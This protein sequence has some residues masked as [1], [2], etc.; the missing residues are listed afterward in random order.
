MHDL[1]TTRLNI[2]HTLSAPRILLVKT[3]SLGDVIHNLPVVSDIAHHYP[4]AR[5]DWLV[6]E[7]FAALPA[8]HPRVRKVIP[9]AIRRWRR[10]LFASSTWRE[11][12]A[13]R[14]NL[15]DEQY[16]F[17][18]DTQGLFKSALL[19]SYARGLRCGYDRNSAREPLA[20]IFY[21]K[22]FAVARARHAVERN[23]QLVASALDYALSDTADFGIVPPPLPRPAW[24][25]EGRYAVLLHATSRDDKLWE[26]AKWVELG[27]HFQLKGIAGILPWGN[28]NE[29]A[30]AARLA[31]QIPN[32]ICTPKMNLN[33][34]AALLGAAYAVIGVDT[35]IA[36]LAAALNKPTIGIYTA[37]DPALTG[38]YAGK[39]TMNLG[40]IANSPDV[41]DVVNA[42]AK[43][44]D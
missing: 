10:N 42:L 20:T 25:A 12:H 3:S 40:G 44:S 37:T 43:L 16:D 18:I 13:L 19:M 22:T 21:Q 29:Q 15:A 35:G 28:A 8:L 24:L 7:G 39:L 31:A 27:K 4:N 9:V 32:A 34:V 17:V 2:L 26:E 23:R 41:Q 33:E 6:E 1:H 30:R 14:R 38:V 11:I 36:H 5:I